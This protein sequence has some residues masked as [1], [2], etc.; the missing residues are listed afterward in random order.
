MIILK[1]TQGATPLSPLQ[2]F[3]KQSNIEFSYFNSCLNPSQ[4]SLFQT[5]NQWYTESLVTHTLFRIKFSSPFLFPPK[6]NPITHQWTFLQDWQK[7]ETKVAN[8][9]KFEF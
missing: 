3:G 4:N 9:F 2:N 1:R 6:K 8:Q 7:Y 5:T